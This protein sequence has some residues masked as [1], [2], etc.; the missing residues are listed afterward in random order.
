MYIMLKHQK[1]S[2]NWCEYS[3]T[4]KDL[5]LLYCMVYWNAF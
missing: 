4:R 5:L 3:T 1:N 2:K